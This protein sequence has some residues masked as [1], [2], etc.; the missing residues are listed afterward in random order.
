MFFKPK[1]IPPAFLIVGVQKAG[2]TALYQYLSN[3]PDIIAPSQKEID[4]FWL[5]HLF[6]KGYSWYE[7]Q[8]PKQ[9][10]F[11]GKRKISFESCP[12]YLFSVTAAKRI[13]EY[14]PE[15]KI[16]IILRNPITRAF[17][18]FQMYQRRRF[19]TE[20][21]KQ[22]AKK[23]GGDI[24]K[25]FEALNAPDFF[26]NFS[27]AI[28]QEWKAIQ[29]GGMQ[30]PHLISQGFYAQQIEN[31]LQFFPRKQML[32]LE[33]QSLKNQ[34]QETLR[35]VASFLEIKEKKWMKNELQKYHEG[36]YQEEINLKTYLK[37]Q[38][39]FKEPNQQLFKLIGRE[40]NW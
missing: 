7:A 21:N 12:H 25:F 22:S 3:H 13:Y 9:T 17:S 2:T 38:K 33:H 23:Y 24:Q 39:I 19:D 15:I 35:H 14:N 37:L 10:T 32:L 18:Q 31:Y 28:E 20:K 5:D 1:T 34:T 29:T 4:F 8:F 40:F 36:N 11:F 6:E 30:A 16:I 26:T 27:E